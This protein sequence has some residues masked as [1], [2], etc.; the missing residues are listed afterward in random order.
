MPP[1][2]ITLFIVVFWLGMTAWLLWRDIW[3]SIAPGEPPS[4]AISR[5]D[6]NIRSQ[7][8]V[9]WKAQYIPRR[10]KPVDYTITTTVAYEAKTDLFTLQARLRPVRPAVRPA[11]EQ[12]KLLH[13]VKLTSESEDKLQPR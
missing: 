1:H 6:D 11:P 2:R 12:E 13:P 5:M 9:P 8:R 4:F 7:P 3:P 10:G